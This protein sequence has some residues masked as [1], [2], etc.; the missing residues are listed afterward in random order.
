LRSVSLLIALAGV[1]VL[2]LAPVAGLDATW[3]LVGLL[4]VVAGVVKVVVVRLWRN[5]ADG[6]GLDEGRAPRAD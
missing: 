2:L 1:A 5:L 3:V 6:P 4:L